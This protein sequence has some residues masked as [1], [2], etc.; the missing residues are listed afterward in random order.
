MP[1]R[2]LH[3]LAVMPGNRFERVFQSQSKPDIAVRTALIED[4]HGHFWRLRVHRRLDTPS[5]VGGDGTGVRQHDYSSVGCASG[6]QHSRYPSSANNRGA[7]YPP[8]RPADAQSASWLFAGISTRKCYRVFETIDLSTY[9][10]TLHRSHLIEIF[11]LKCTSHWLVRG[12]IRIYGNTEQI[13]GRDR[14]G[15]RRN[16]RSGRLVVGPAQRV[17]LDR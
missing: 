13:I 7:T 16:Q 9:P 6:A 11:E 10:L 5:I 2:K 1:F 15:S 8:P 12:K 17:L 14:A 3:K 4:A